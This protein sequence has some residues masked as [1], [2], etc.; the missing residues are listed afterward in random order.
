MPIFTFCKE[1][2]A[3]LLPLGYFVA[4][5]ALWPN[6]CEITLCTVCAKEELWLKRLMHNQDFLPEPSVDAKL[7]VGEKGNTFLSFFSIE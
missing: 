7:N 6:V 2:K 4:I 3:E 1:A 5:H